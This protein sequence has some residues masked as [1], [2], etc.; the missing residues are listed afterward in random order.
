LQ[1]SDFQAPAGLNSAAII[2]DNAVGGWYWAILPPNA[3]A[4]LNKTGITQLRLAFPL[5]DNDDLGAD[6][7]TFFSGDAE[8]QALRPHLV[9]EYYVP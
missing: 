5:D 4:Y 1:A 8:D 9:V 7:I 3:F 6:Y 2:Q